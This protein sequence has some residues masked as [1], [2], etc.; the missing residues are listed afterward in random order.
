MNG[1]GFVQVV[2]PR[3]RAS[4]PEQTI[5]DRTGHQLR[6]LLRRAE[7]EPPSQPLTLSLP[8]PLAERLARR[9]D[10]QAELERRRGARVS[11]T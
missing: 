1:F 4:I 9:P 2:R 3:V 5:D 10:W 7:R 6:A 8:P 11:V